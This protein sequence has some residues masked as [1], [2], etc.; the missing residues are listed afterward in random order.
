MSR[1]VIASVFVVA[2]FAVAATTADAEK[3][4]KKI[5]PRT[6]YLESDDLT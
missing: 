5:P 6:V 1:I 2:L 4:V 3:R